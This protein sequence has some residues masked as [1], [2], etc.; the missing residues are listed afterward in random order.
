[1]RIICGSTYYKH[2]ENIL[3]FSG[4]GINGDFFNFF[5]KTNR[6]HLFQY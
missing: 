2:S 4:K 6:T 5:L 3:H 1:M